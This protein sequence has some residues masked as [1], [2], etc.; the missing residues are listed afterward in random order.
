VQPS[1]DQPIPD[2]IYRETGADAARRDDDARWEGRWDQ[3]GIMDT[4]EHDF[5][6]D[7]PSN[8]EADETGGVEDSDGS[9]PGGER[10]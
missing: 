3:S 6:P 4:L 5:D 2:D 7:I 1:T 10:R 9:G 8:D